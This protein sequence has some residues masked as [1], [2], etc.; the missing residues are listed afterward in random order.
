MRREFESKPIA[1]QLAEKTLQVCT[2]H[3]EYQF[4][5]DSEPDLFACSAN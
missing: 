3:G 1:L 5:P 4:L 2:D